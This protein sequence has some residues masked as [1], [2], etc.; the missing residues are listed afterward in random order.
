[1]NLGVL[2]GSMG[3]PEQL[4]SDLTRGGNGN[5]GSVKQSVPTE[6]KKY[7]KIMNFPPFRPYKQDSED[8]AVYMGDL[9]RLLVGAAVD[10]DLRTRALMLYNPGDVGE[11]V[12]DNVLS[13]Y[14]SW[15]EA[16]A[17]FSGS[18]LDPWF[19]VSGPRGSLTPSRPGA[20][21]QC[22]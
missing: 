14:K 5:G 6:G 3:L 15:D 4:V 9:H 12:E 10:T 17:A 13:N 7:S 18:S 11:W 16:R 22:T 1:M 2:R 20:R 21:W 8:P 19:S